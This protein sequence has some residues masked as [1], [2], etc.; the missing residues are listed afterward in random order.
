MTVDKLAV[1]TQRGFLDVGKRIDGVETRM[2]GLQDEMREGFKTLTTQI[3]T[4]AK[5]MQEG[6]Q[7]VHAWIDVIHHDIADLPAIREELHDLRARIDK[8]E[9]KAAR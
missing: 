9:R 6:F 8:L 2:D 1:M 7:H 5:V 4:L 3:Q